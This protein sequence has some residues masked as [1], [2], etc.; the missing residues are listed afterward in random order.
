LTNAIPVIKTTIKNEIAS[1]EVALLRRLNCTDLGLSLVSVQ[2]SICGQFLGGLDAL[3]L[4]YAVLGVT[5][6]LS[7]PAM[8]YAANR[9]LAHTFRIDP[10]SPVSPVADKGEKGKSAPKKANVKKTFPD[11]DEPKGG[12][13]VQIT[14]H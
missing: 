5:A 10:E 13:T 6:A 1:E 2:D 9:L 11:E 4:A 14:I 3:W 7:M 8:I 12:R